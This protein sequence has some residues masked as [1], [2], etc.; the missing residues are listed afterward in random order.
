MT[1]RQPWTRPVARGVIAVVTGAVA[2][3]ITAAPAAAKPTTVK[4]E[5]TDAGCP[6]RLETKAGRTTFKVEN[7]DATSVSEFEVLRRGRILGERE[8]LAP[9]LSGEFSVTLKPGTY[10]IYCPGGDREKGKLVVT[11]RTAG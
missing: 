11:P 5:L 9:G 4:V 8:N 1:S 3:G 7:V 2:L 6:K 10:T